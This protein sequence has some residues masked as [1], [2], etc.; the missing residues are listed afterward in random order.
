MF[1]IICVLTFSEQVNPNKTKAKINFLNYR[2]IGEILFL[3]L[4]LRTLITHE[5]QTKKNCVILYTCN[6]IKYI[7]SIFRV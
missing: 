5:K 1:V 3:K 6:V 4:N 7:V 2:K